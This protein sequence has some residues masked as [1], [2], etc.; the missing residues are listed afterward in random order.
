MKLS[1]LTFTLFSFARGN[2]WPNQEREYVTENPYNIFQDSS[3]GPSNIPILSTSILPPLK[4]DSISWVEFAR[5]NEGSTK[6]SSL[7][8]V[9]PTEATFSEPIGV[10]KIDRYS[11][12]LT[13]PI[14]IISP[15]T[16]RTPVL[17][18]VINQRTITVAPDG[19]ANII[20]IERNGEI[21]SDDRSKK[22]FLCGSLRNELI[23][24]RPGSG[25]V[26]IKGASRVAI[27][28]D[29]AQ[30]SVI[31]CPPS[32]SLIPPSFTDERLPMDLER[33]PLTP[34]SGVLLSEQPKTRSSN[35]RPSTIL[36]KDYLLPPYTY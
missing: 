32:T 21:A 9:N 22:L 2:I 5:N 11:T 27:I 13:S 30:N 29:D 19:N 20:G 23:V 14:E 15:E 12:S 33:K 3:V 35:E 18:S 16:R 4:K 24:S 36:L 10:N 7:I 25:S 26:F 6:K 17:E 28:D 8:V 34:R 1:I 31:V